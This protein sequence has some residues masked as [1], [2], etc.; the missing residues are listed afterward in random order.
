L[1]RVQVVPVL[2]G[3]AIS[4]PDGSTDDYEM[5]CQAMMLLFKPWQSFKDL[6]ID[7]KT[8]A[9]SFEQQNFAPV[10]CSI[11]INMNVE[12]ECKEAQDVHA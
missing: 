11:I 4:Q 7:D 3:T 12:N 8:W 1:R 5:H 10:F 9:E 6:K 2:L